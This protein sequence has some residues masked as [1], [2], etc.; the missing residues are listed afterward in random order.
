M[1]SGPTQVRHKTACTESEAN[2]GPKLETLFER[3]GTSR[4]LTSRRGDDSKPD[5]QMRRNTHSFSSIISLQTNNPGNPLTASKRT[6]SQSNLSK[7]SENGQQNGFSEKRPTM[8]RYRSDTNLNIHSNNNAL[9]PSSRFNRVSTTGKPRKIRTNGQG[10]SKPAPI[11][12]EVKRESQATQLQQEQTLNAQNLRLQ[13]TSSAGDPEAQEDYEM[14]QRI[15]EWLD[16]V[17]N[18]AIEHPPSQD[19]LDE[20]PP[21]TDTAIHIV[22]NGDD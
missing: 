7:V 9:M 6:K 13:S 19:I 2:P 4:A 22:W 14:R 12:R 1:S 11:V 20:G 8:T 18:A 15:H 3:N 10:P 5:V 17:D 16:G 21:Q